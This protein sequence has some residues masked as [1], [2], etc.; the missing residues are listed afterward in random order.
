MPSASVY[1]KRYR[2]EEGLVPFLAYFD[3]AFLLDV[4]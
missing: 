3:F 1:S 2:E 4:T